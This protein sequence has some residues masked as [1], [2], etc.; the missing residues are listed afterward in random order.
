M[1]SNT[2]SSSSKVKPRQRPGDRCGCND[3]VSDIG[4]M[5]ARL[6][7]QCKRISL[8]RFTEDFRQLRIGCVAVE[9]PRENAPEVLPFR[10]IDFGAYRRGR[11]VRPERR[12]VELPR[13]FRDRMLVHGAGRAL[14]YPVI[15]YAFFVLAGRRLRGL[16]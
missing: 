14:Q 4:A 1:M 16:L 6:L 11:V 5:T 9:L 2:T 15:L 10:V 8:V 12:A 13:L 3:A 7:F